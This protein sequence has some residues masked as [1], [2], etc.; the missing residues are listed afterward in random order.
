MAACSAR[1]KRLMEEGLRKVTTLGAAEPEV[2]DI[3]AWVNKSR[4][5]EA[6]AKRIAERAAAAK[7]SSMYDEE[8]RIP[9]GMAPTTQFNSVG[10]GCTLC[11][12]ICGG[13]VHSLKR[14][15]GGGTL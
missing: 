7:L 4:E 13:E 14:G 9:W 15:E 1:E 5:A 12:E 3:S 11:Q 10:E 2:D 6:E 8:V